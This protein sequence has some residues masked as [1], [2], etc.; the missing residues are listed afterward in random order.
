VGI[1]SKTIRHTKRY[2]E[3]ASVLIKYGMG[4]AV[5][6]LNIADTPILRKLIPTKDARPI[7]DFTRWEDIRMALEELGPGFVKLGQM[8][9][10]RSDILPTELIAELEKL[11]D[12]VPPF[13]TDAALDLV[14][15]ELDASISDLFQ[16]FEAEPI[17]SASIGQV[18]RAQ[19]FDG[20]KVAVKVQRPNIEETIKV[21]LEILHNL[22][23]LAEKNLEQFKYINPTG[24]VA[25]FDRH[26]RQELNYNHER[27]NLERFRKFYGDEEGLII[28]K[29]YRELSTKR[30][31]T[32]DFMEG[33]KVSR[34]ADENLPGY[35]RKLIAERGAKMILKQIFIN[36]FFHADPHPGNIMVMG[37]ASIC[38]LDF[39]MM[40]V[41][42]PTQQDQLGALLL[43]LDKRD[44]ALLT[45]LLLD[46]AKNPD[47]PDIG[48]LE[49]E[50]HSLMEKYIDLPLEDMDTAALIDD[51]TSVIKRF[52]LRMPS[53]FAMMTRAIVMIEGIG[54]QLYP[55][56]QI[57][58]T[59]KSFQSSILRHRFKP[60]RLLYDGFL[61]SLRYR[62]VFTELPDNLRAF[63]RK[64]LRG[65]LK[66]ELEHLGLDPMR[67]TLEAA[68]YRLVF[69]MLTAALIVGSAIMVHAES[70]R[71]PI[72]STFGFIGFLLGGICAVVV[73][74][75]SIYRTLKE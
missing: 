20:T 58:S 62:R 15:R 43:A 3:I 27:H 59:L 56:F 31:L 69:G 51:I 1:V 67:A 66:L 72:L 4:E 74:F 33:V 46:V 24:I 50:I 44:S 73:L 14:E 35:D 6:A 41:L 34:I 48:S 45:S 71:W 39:G 18:Y 38:F 63:A 47:Y 53:N 9:S 54:R 49:Y 12:E 8:L 55:D 25:E 5:R 64:L 57:N 37:D 7:S 32:M 30:V 16:E 19:L 10:N 22:A 26:I 13:D 75:I 17:A 65:R 28:P 40:G 60:Q 11:Q 36:G 2:Q 23:K 52:R 70:E 29:I 21:D 61:T 68:S 42:M